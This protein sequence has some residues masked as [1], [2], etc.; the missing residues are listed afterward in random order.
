MAAEHSPTSCKLCVEA[1]C[2]GYS[3]GQAHG[4]E[5][6]GYNVGWEHGQMTE[7]QRIR[8]ILAEMFHRVPEP[9]L[10]EFLKLIGE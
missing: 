8:A 10:D 5:R 3:L 1:Y 4:R 2:R 9:F 7:R 6:D